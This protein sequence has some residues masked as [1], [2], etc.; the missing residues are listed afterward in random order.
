MRSEKPEEE[1]SETHPGVIFLPSH[2]S[3]GPKLS[4][5]DPYFCPWPASIVRYI[6]TNDE[7]LDRTTPLDR[8][9]FIPVSIRCHVKGHAVTRLIYLNS[10]YHR[11]LKKCQMS[12]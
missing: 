7:R 3:V 11:S 9:F 5:V 2:W 4:V 12:P 6:I 1:Q 10:V 8:E